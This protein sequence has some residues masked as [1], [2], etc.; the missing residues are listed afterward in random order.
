M[1]ACTVKKEIYQD[2]AAMLA[3]DMQR[4]DVYMRRD[5]HDGSHCNDCCLYSKVG[6]DK[7]PQLMVL[8]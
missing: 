5:D 1:E 4:T 2:R 3:K 6:K 8:K 7:L